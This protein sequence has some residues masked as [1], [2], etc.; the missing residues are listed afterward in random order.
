MLSADL[1]YF[2]NIAR[3]ILQGL[4]PYS[5][6][7]VYPPATS[8]LF[9]LFGLVSFQIA[10]W[11]WAGVNLLTTLDII[12]RLP[13]T[14][15][16]WLWLL[17]S[18]LVF[19]VLDGQ[20]DLVFLWLALNL[21]RK[22]WRAGVAAGLMLLK[23]QIAFVVLPWYLIRWLLHDRKQILRFMGM[24]VVLAV[25]PLVIRPTVYAEYLVA[26]QAQT[27]LRVAASPGFFA[28]TT[29][30]VPIWIP[31]LL[32]GLFALAGLWLDVRSSWAAQLLALPGGRWYDSVLLLNAAPVWFAVPLSW[33]TCALAAW[34]KNSVPLMLI[35][36]GILLWR[37]L[38]KIRPI[39]YNTASSGG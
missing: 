29:F 13:A 4:G 18:P 30:A 5:V 20:N 25:F 22:D 11:T 24:A 9:V 27:G 14:R 31:A 39:R 7:N 33:L 21:E 37:L 17:F 1:L 12:R 19:I 32:G 28:F 35:P 23:P 2:W 8:Y 38:A 15:L 36:V 16:R 34:L 6:T 10:A 26:A 3:A